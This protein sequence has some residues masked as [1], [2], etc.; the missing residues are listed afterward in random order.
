MSS[1]RLLSAAPDPLQRA[2]AGAAFLDSLNI[3]DWRSKIDLNKLHIHF[4][5]TCMFGQLCGSYN[6]VKDTVFGGRSPVALGFYPKGG[7]NDI[8]DSRALTRAWRSI[9]RAEKAVAELAS[10]ARAPARR[11]AALV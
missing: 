8:E 2:A 3:G 7:V 6:R 11:E 5:D 1:Q 4:D 9:I 10:R